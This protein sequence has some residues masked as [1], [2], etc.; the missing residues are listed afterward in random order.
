M[1]INE[2]KSLV[3]KAGINLVESGLIARTWGNV[4]CRVD[5]NTFVITPSGRSYNT[6]T[7]DEIVEVNINNLSYS[8]D[9]KPSSEKGIHAGA[10]KLRPDI[11]FIIHTHQEYASAIAASA[12]DLI[13]LKS[14]EPLLN[15]NVICAKYALPGTKALRKNVISALKSSKTNAVIMKYHGALCF[16]K[17]YNEAFMVAEELE[18][19]CEEFIVRKYLSLSKRKS[20]NVFEMSK[21]AVLQN[22]QVK[23]ISIKNIS[24]RYLNCSRNKNSI[25]LYGDGKEIEINHNDISSSCYEEAGI[26]D[27]ILSNNKDINHIIFFN[28]PYIA[29]ICNGMQEFKPILDDFAQIAGSHVKVIINDKT[30]ISKA[31][32]KSPVVFIKDVGILCCGKT[33]DDAEAVRMVTSKTSKA[34]IGASLF[35]KVQPI[36]HL[37]CLLMR[38]VYVKKYS[39]K[40]LKK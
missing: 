28:S 24:K 11:N 30:A 16:G 17:N 4:S 40:A 2:A 6:L 7:P 19:G 5:E 26:Y 1:D 39:K 34:Y 32:K 3:I 22:S 31:L 18:K 12:L 33:N 15:G 29:A 36:K 25:L 35:G 27:F 38:Y 23:N 10:Y 9:I 13:N 20:Y 14:Q 8:G 37:E 21:F